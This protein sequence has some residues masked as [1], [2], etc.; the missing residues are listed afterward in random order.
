MKEYVQR[1]LVPSSSNYILNT[2][3]VSETVKGA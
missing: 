1:M 2:H 3:F